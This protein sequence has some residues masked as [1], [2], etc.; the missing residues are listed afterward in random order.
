MVHG[1]SMRIA[2]VGVAEMAGPLQGRLAHLFPSGRKPPFLELPD[3]QALG[4]L[5]RHKLSAEDLKPKIPGLSGAR[6]RL[7]FIRRRQ[8]GARRLAKMRSVLRSILYWIKVL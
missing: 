8:V 6:P 4:H 5:S 7:G 1:E 3:L 2:W